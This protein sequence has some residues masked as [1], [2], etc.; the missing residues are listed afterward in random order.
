ML[1]S[2][3]WMRRLCAPFGETF[4]S[5]VLPPFVSY[6]AAG[7][8]LSVSDLQCRL[9]EASLHRNTQGSRLTGG[10]KCGSCRL[11]SPILYFP[12]ERWFSVIIQCSP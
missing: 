6:G 12:R 3:P 2:V 1:S 10:P 5:D 8:E 4:E 11:R 7:R 9:D